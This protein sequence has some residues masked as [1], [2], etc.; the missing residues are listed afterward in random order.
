VSAERGGTSFSIVHTTQYEY[1]EAVSI[2]HHMVRLTPRTLP[3]QACER[4]DLEIEPLASVEKNHLDYFGNT[5][6]FFAMQAAHRRLTVRARSRVIVSGKAG[7]PL[8]ENLPWERAADWTALP[9]DAI[10]CALESRPNRIG[11]EI[12]SFARPSF[13]S[14]RPLL[15][16]V[17]DL[18]ARIHRGFTYDRRATTVATSLAE[19]FETRRGVCQDFARL[20]IACLRSLRIAAR[21]VSGYLETS[22]PEGT[23]RPVGAD[24]SHAWLAVYAPDVGW[25]DVDPTNNLFPSGS[26]VT[27]AWGRDYVDVSPTRGVILGG[28]DH[29]LKVSV[30]MARSPT[31]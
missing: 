4:H 20:E 13:P 26:H 9:L 5:M 12:A 17:A 21:Y 15:E 8:G 6:T 19:V 31:P 11:P 1:S 18:T 10:E 28:G 3:H 2:S 29:T 23:P 16:A 24:A 25:V 30:E 27:V 14:G 7:P 22:S